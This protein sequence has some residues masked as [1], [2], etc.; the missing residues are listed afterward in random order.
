MKT[1]IVVL[2]TVLLSLTAQAQEKVD[3]KLPKTSASEEMGVGKGFML[4]GAM[5]CVGSALFV[6]NNSGGKSSAGALFAL[7]MA[8]HSTGLVVYTMG[9]RK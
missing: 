7:G 8:T 1:T 9:K 3:L 2:A 4:T 5:M 6:T